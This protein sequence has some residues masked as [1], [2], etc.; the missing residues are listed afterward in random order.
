MPTIF[1]HAIVPLAAGLALGLATIF[2]E[3]LWVW[4]PALTMLLIGCRIFPKIG[5][6]K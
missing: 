1:T 2:S 4:L 3:I 5:L 6:I